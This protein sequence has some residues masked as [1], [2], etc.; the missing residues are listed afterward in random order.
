MADNTFLKVAAI[1]VGGYFLY[2]Y[3]VT[4]A[5]N[6]TPNPSSST[7]SAPLAP[8]TLAQPLG[9]QDAMQ[10]LS[11]GQP[12]S[13]TQWAQYYQTINPGAQLPA[14]SD[15]FPSVDLTQAMPVNTFLASVFQYAN[16][17]PIPIPSD[18]TILPPTP[19]A[20]S[21]PPVQGPLQSAAVDAIYSQ[22]LPS[23]AGD[24]NFTGSGSQ[25]SA[26]PY[27]WNFYLQRLLPAGIP[28][29][30]PCSLFP[31]V[32][33]S[34]PMTLATYWQGMSYAL[35]ALPGMAGLGR[36]PRLQALGARLQARRG[37][38]DV[39][40]PATPVD[41]LTPGSVVQLASGDYMQVGEGMTPNPY[42]LDVQLPGTGTSSL[43][44]IG[45]VA[46]GALL[47]V[48]MASKR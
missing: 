23:V 25:T 31:G 42:T 30:G 40:G 15:I 7:G 47:L 26:T 27:Q 1:G 11:G 12:T 9:L 41:M 34:Q 39:Q 2:E 44:M 10:S 3:L 38:G 32:D 21:S 17:H 45:L 46:G 19:P 14:L 13:A 8:S 18:G 4:P 36:L 20:L 35:G 16:S 5:T 43:G 22:L 24:P 33:C 37:V 28:A 6:A 48:L 29:P